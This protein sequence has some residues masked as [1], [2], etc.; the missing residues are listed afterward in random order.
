MNLRIPQSLT[1]QFALAVS[2]LLLVMIAIGATTVYTL[3]SSAE[4]I[5]QLAGQR[6][7][8]FQDAQDLVHRTLLIERMALQLSSI[9]TPGGVRETHRQVIGELE[10]FDLLVDRLATAAASDNVEVLDLHRSS[11]VFRNTVNIVAQLRES[12]PSVESAANDGSRR[13]SVMRGLSEELRRQA[14]ALAAAAR[15]QTAFFTRDYREAVQSLV[16][17]SDRTRRWVVT[18]V[19][20]SLLLAW[21]I[22]REFLGRHIVTRLRQVSHHLRHGDIDAGPASVPVQGSDEIADMARAV[23][24]FLE[25]RWQ[26]K[27]AEQ[28]V[29]ALNAQLEQRVAQRTAELTLASARQQ[30]EILERKRAEHALRESERF[31]NSV[32]ENIPGM[33]FVK[34]AKELRFVRF[35]KAGEEMVGL[36][37]QQLIGKGDHD[38]FPKE[39][40][41]FFISMD[42]AVLR[43]KELLDIPEETIQTTHHGT[44]ILHTKKIPILDGDG[45]PQYLLGISE[46]ITQRKQAETEL[47]RHREHLEELIRERTAQLV[48]AKEQADAANQAKSAF[49][50]RMSHELRTPLNAVLGYTQILLHDDNLGERQLAALRT[51]ERSGEGLLA[52]IN[53]ILD[54]SKIEAEKFDLFPAPVALLSFVQ[55]IAALIR[56]RAEKKGLHF[57]HETSAE[58]PQTIRADENRL[59]QVLLNLLDNAVKFTDRG[60][61][62]LHVR[63]LRRRPRDVELQFEVQDTGVGI[64]EKD[65]AMIFR[66]FEQVGDERRRFNGTGLGLAISGQLV[67]LMGSDIHVES[68]PGA[69]SRFWFTLTVPIGQDMAARPPSQAAISGYTGRRQRVLIVDDVATNRALLVDML[70]PIGFELSEAAGGAQAL[71]QVAARAPDLVLMDVMMPVMD[72]LEAIRRLR[73]LSGLERLPVIAVSA[74]ASG[75][76]QRSCLAAGASSFI[77]KPIKQ[78]ALLQQIGAHLGLTW[79]VGGSAEAGAVVEPTLVAPPVQEMRRLHQLARA[80]NMRGVREWSDEVAALDARFHPFANLLRRLADG[81]ESKAIVA[82]SKQ[83]ARSG[84][85]GE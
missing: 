34:D 35:N 46:D 80:G 22:T 17:V 81:F 28:E 53:G 25:D 23:E 43:D 9:D 3:S 40:A 31:L 41:D 37:R 10:A 19:G 75:A 29:L 11:Q 12:A 67:R 58:L 56:V 48:I 14:E 30:A 16:D 52:L 49:L 36:S 7:T 77:A 1:A 71:E 15:Q 78:E 44:R 60:E 66:P 50:A 42:R 68:R 8:R 55:D 74:S 83:Y 72:G 2:A 64:D 73:R 61:L 47:L 38:F 85:D 63:V 21:L 26:R 4:S 6:L 5:R 27:Q 62:I 24:Q 51:I 33:V 32:V 76:D 20:V 39:Q 69:G 65:L 84:E 59:R 45:V 79:V 18:L 82:L 54:L 70:K 13:S 57:R